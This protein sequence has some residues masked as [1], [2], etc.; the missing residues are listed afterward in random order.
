MVLREADAVAEGRD[1]VAV[2]EELRVVERVR[3]AVAVEERVT[4]LESDGEEAEGEGRE[5]VRVAERLWDEEAVRVG[6]TVWVVSERD[7]ALGVGLQVVVREGVLEK[8]R[9]A[10]GVG[11]S[12]AEGPLAESVTVRVTDCETVGVWEGEPEEERTAD[13]VGV[14]EEV[15]V[16]EAEAVAVVVTVADA[17]AVALRVGVAEL[18]ER[19]PVGEP[20]LRDA[21]H[22]ALG[23]ESVPVREKVRVAT[24]VAVGVGEAE[25]DAVGGVWLG[26]GVNE[27]LR[28]RVPDEEKV[29]VGWGVGVSESDNVWVGEAEGEMEALRVRTS[30][31]DWVRVAAGDRV[32][33]DDRVAVRVAVAEPLWL[34]VPV[35][36]TLWVTMAE[37]VCVVDTVKLADRDTLEVGVWEEEAVWLALEEALWVVLW[38]TVREA[39]DVADR[40]SEKVALAEPEALQEMLREQLG[41][42]LAVGRAVAVTVQVGVALEERDGEKLRVVLQLPL[43]DR[44]REAETLDVAVQEPEG[45]VAERTHVAVPVEE[46]EHVLEKVGD[47]QAEKV[48][49]GLAEGESEGVALG[50]AEGVPEGADGVAVVADGVRVWDGE[51]VVEGLGDGGEAEGDREWLREEVGVEVRV[52]GLGVTVAPEAVQVGVCER[53]GTW[54]HVAVWEAD[55][56][57][58]ELGLRDA[59]R[60]EERVELAVLLREQVEVPLME[61]LREPLGLKVAVGTVVGVPVR[62]CDALGDMLLDWDPVLELE[63]VSAGLWVGEVEVEAEEEQEVLALDVSVQLE[64]AVKEKRELRLVERLPV[65]ERE[66]DKEGELERDME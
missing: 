13:H 63:R 28:L 61:Q 18:H 4:E 52:E 25:A 48:G 49:V 66:A 2:M 46:P 59:E 15:R 34:L 45:P 37:E 3:L 9:V 6:D 23:G 40:G 30:D 19:V 44:V 16:C 21:E 58:L 35:P 50:E 56:L 39:V 57:L 51:K 7:R 11:V 32:K 47:T 41:L 53:L 10:A 24:L 55:A 42:W 38:L 5:G 64:E 17:T 20:G 14:G 60:D 33:V 22:V 8:E 29:W 31:R 27:R 65:W 1:A 36:V 54:V 62:L 12:V 26:L 43:R